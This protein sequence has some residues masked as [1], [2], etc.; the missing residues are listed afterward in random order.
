MLV[1]LQIN[2]DARA[3]LDLP[4]SKGVISTCSIDFP[5]QKEHD[6]LSQDC[7]TPNWQP[8][9]QYQEPGKLNKGDNGHFATLEKT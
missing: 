6:Q 9:Q 3:S 8:F 2:L 4:T 5:G 1:S 7:P